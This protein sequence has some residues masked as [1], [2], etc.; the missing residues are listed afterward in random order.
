MAKPKLSINDALASAKR[1]CQD[2]EAENEE[3]EENNAPPP[4]APKVLAKTKSTSTEILEDE[5]MPL[6]VL[7]H[8][9]RHTTGLRHRTRLRLQDAVDGQK[10]KPRYGRL[11]SDLTC[12]Q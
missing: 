6:N 5:G 4:E 9:V 11:L 8:W 1:L 3:V 2:I 10:K 12:P 7:S